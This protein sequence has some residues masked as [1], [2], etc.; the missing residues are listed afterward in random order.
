ML[1]EWQKRVRESLLG[2]DTAPDLFRA[3]AERVHL[4][5]EGYWLRVSESLRE[6]FPLTERLLGRAIFESRAREFLGMK[7]EYELELSELSASFEGWLRDRGTAALARAVTLDGL[8]IQSRRAPEVLGG[9]RFGLHPSVRFFDHGDRSYV[10]W[11]DERGYVLSERVPSGTVAILRRLRD[12]VDTHEIAERMA[13]AG[14]D[15]L[16]LRD[17]LDECRDA[18]ILVYQK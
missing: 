9:S 2:T 1:H 4:Y 11:R 14:Q 7:R 15:F 10:F 3:H 16:S 8:A 13:G 18:G 5:R 17:T 12:P 6:D